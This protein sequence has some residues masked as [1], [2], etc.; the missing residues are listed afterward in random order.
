MTNLCSTVFDGHTGEHGAGEPTD[1]RIDGRWA[2][3]VSLFLHKNLWSE[4]RAGQITINQ[5]T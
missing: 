1:E 2:E 5:T 4:R 3:T